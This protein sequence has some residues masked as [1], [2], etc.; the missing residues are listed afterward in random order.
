MTT[1]CSSFARKGGWFTTVPLALLLVA[2][3]FRGSTSE[4]PGPAAI[5]PVSQTQSLA[6]LRARLEIAKH[7]RHTRQ[8]SQ[9]EP[10][11][12]GLLA[13]TS[14]DSIKQEAL[15]ELAAAATDEDQLPRAQQ[16]YAQYLNHWPND[17]WVPEILLRQGRL[18]RQLGLNNLALAKFYSVMTSA[19]VL[20]NDR[21]EYYQK[22]VL[23]AQMEIAETHF[24]L[25]KYAEAAD[26]FSRLLKQNNSALNHPSTQYRLIRCLSGL[27]RNDELVPQAMDFLA[28]YPEVPEQPEV[29]FRLAQGLKQLGRGNEA[30]EQVLWLLREQKE[31]TK[32][33]PELWSYWQQRAGNKIGN[34]LYREGDYL[35]ALEI[36]LTLARLDDAPDWRLPAVY[37]VGLTYEKLS[38]PAKAWNS[39]QDILRQASELGTNASPGLQSVLEMARWRASFL[40][41]QTNAAFQNSTLIKPPPAPATKPSRASLKTTDQP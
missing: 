5:E 33:H 8:P 10:I 32:N 23:E 26:F 41:W 12:V 18:F 37:Q 35:K 3:P 4:L 14:P 1:N 40:Q 17:P 11:L 19:L 30:L 31:R 2:A 27:E 28:H 22:L 16:V 7:L 13:N 24:Q 29:R 25:G 20:K 6:E 38:Q 15:L 36:Y 34:E 21:L 39:Y 9:A